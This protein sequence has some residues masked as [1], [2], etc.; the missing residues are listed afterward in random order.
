MAGFK[1]RL[2]RVKMHGKIIFEDSNFILWTKPGRIGST[3][4]FF[5]YPDQSYRNEPKIAG[6]GKPFMVTSP[7]FDADHRPH[8]CPEIRGA[9]GEQNGELYFGGCP[10]FIFLLWHVCFFL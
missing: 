4:G 9:K 7:Y 1:S 10:A 3:A 2:T 5:G 6:L 8:M